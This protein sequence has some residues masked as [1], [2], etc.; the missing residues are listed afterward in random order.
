[1]IIA[2][3]PLARTIRILGKDRSSLLIHPENYTAPLG[4]QNE[5]VDIQRE[6]SWAWTCGSVSI[7]IEGRGP[8]FLGLTIGELKM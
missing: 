5:V 1:M 4:S 2:R 6:S 3:C 8:G 7:G